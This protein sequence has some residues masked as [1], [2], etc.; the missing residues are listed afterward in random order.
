MLIPLLQLTKTAHGIVSSHPDLIGFRQLTA[1]P[2]GHAPSPTP[3]HFPCLH[4]LPFHV[5]LSASSARI[6]SNDARLSHP[7]GRPPNK[8][9]DVPRS[10]G[11]A[12][13]HGA[14]LPT[15]SIPA[16]R[17]NLLRDLP[18]SFRHKDNDGDVL[19]SRAINRCGN[20][21]PSLSTVCALAYP[22]RK[23]LLS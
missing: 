10:K 17:R 15:A 22:R 12:P 18:E 8:I 13:K 1:A 5:W 6:R 21:L 19:P 9:L 4:V 7:N 2:S 3:S 16:P 11:P 20:Y 23:C 14:R